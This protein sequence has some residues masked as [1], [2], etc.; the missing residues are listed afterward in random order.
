MDKQ[1]LDKIIDLAVVIQQIPAPTFFEHQRGD[2]IRG[3]FL[4]EGLSN[5]SLDSIGNVYGCLPGGGR[6]QPVVVSAHMDSVFPASTELYVVRNEDKI[7]GPGIGD[8]AAGLAALFGLLWVLRMREIQLP[9]DVWFVANVGE[10]GVGDLQ[11]MQAVVNRFENHARAYLVVEGMALGQVYHQGLAVRRYRIRVETAGGHSW[12]NFGF[13]SAIHELAALVTHLVG[14]PLPKKPRVTLNVGL[15]SGGISVNTIAAE[16]SIELDLRSEDERWLSRLSGRVEELVQKADRES[17]HASAQIIGQRP[18]GSIPVDHP[19]VHLAKSCLEAQGIQPH[20]NIG[21]T[22]AN[23]PLSRGLP[24]V[25]VGIT[26]GNGA[27]TTHETIQT[28]PFNQGIAQLADLV[29]G[30]FSLSK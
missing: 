4:A 7:V 30:A 24:A 2:F 9:G 22:D 27:H 1:L 14:I 3:R 10:E 5:V 25:C 18:P 6:I 12:V 15:I 21:S 29:E 13:P 19:L 11:G 23:I 8:N 26:T 28:Q 16:A 20:L 17:V